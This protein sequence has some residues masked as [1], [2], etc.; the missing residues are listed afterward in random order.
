M[1]C[2]RCPHCGVEMESP[3]SLAGQTETC[4]SC[5]GECLIPPAAEQSPRA[6]PSALSESGPA[7]TGAAGTTAAAAV[8]SGG[9][10]I[11]A[12]AAA[13][14]VLVAGAAGAW[15]LLKP[16]GTSG[17]YGVG[18]P[19]G[20]TD[21]FCGTWKC[22]R[23]TPG[24]E[25]FTDAHNAYKQPV[26]IEKLAAAI[27]RPDSDALK[28]LYVVRTRNSRGLQADISERDKDGIHWPNPITQG[29]E[30]FTMDGD[31]LK[32]SWTLPAT[33]P[34]EAWYERVEDA[35]I[36]SGTGAARNASVQRAYVT[37]MRQV[38]S[39]RLYKE[40]LQHRAIR[41]ATAGKSF[42]DKAA[43]PYHPEA[44]WEQLQAELLH[45][46]ELVVP[47]SDPPILL[48][49]NAYERT[50]D[51]LLHV[52]PDY[53]KKVGDLI[54]R[55]IA[56]RLAAAG[57]DS[58]R[59]AAEEIVRTGR[60]HIL[61]LDL[62]K[63]DAVVR[64]VIRRQNDTGVAN[65]LAGQLR[66]YDPKTAE[67][68]AVDLRK[69]A[70]A[71]KIDATP[72]A[73]HQYGKPSTD[74]DKLLA[75]QLVPVVAETLS[76]SPAEKLNARH[77]MTR[78]P[79]RTCLFLLIAP[80]FEA[81]NLTAQD[82]E[83]FKTHFDAHAEF[84]C[85]GGWQGSRSFARKVEAGAKWG[86][87]VAAAM[88]HTD[89]LMPLVRSAVP[90]NSE[91]AYL[92]LQYRTSTPGMSQTGMAIQEAMFGDR[93]KSKPAAGDEEGS[94]AAYD[95]FCKLV[96]DHAK[97]FGVKTKTSGTRRKD[98]MAYMERTWPFAPAD[99]M[100]QMVLKSK[101]PLKE[102]DDLAFA[103]AW[104]AEMMRNSTS[105]ML[106]GDYGLKNYL[107]AHPKGAYAGLA[108]QWLAAQ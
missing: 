108:N 84:I 32:L 90:R 96:C 79:M 99:L 8:K 64:D 20:P 73:R 71:N 17:P 74:W 97:E 53:S 75:R 37:A 4:P 101:P 98:F 5:Q 31:Q 34:I 89:K 38:E 29:P 51:E 77:G 54:K 93:V 16:G 76:K 12:I 94:R 87:L 100:L 63:F 107:A 43:I 44:M 83:T 60:E 25:L 95:H 9:G 14:A 26:T 30:V 35:A 46:G 104:S 36:L 58:H 18:T 19:A 105:M 40:H 39:D 23:T 22:V 50:L 15:L 47:G 85:G 86:A 57:K 52:A 92:L 78:L 7:A 3:D 6:H 62:A 55:S 2:F 91:L 103:V 80:L 21:E 10:K 13:A 24:M 68:L 41:R 81:E 106:F 69:H 72:W 102:R 59:R 66:R 61:N 11:I 1:I 65:R 45:A 42:K 67:S 56:E 27:D 48:P 49:A 33:K 70:A 28:N 88:R 82:V